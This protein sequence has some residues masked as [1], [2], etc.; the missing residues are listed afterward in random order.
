M[1]NYNLHVSLDGVAW[2]HQEPAYDTLQEATI[3]ALDYDDHFLFLEPIQDAVFETAPEAD[4]DSEPIQ[5]RST[6]RATTVQYAVKALVWLAGASLWIADRTIQLMLLLQQNSRRFAP[7]ER[8]AWPR[9]LKQQLMRRQHSRC[10]Y[11]GNRFSAQYFD[12]DHMMPAAIGGSNEASNLQV[13]CGPCNRRKGDQ[14]DQEFRRRYASLVPQRRLT[15][16]RRPVPQRAFDAVTRSS[17]ASTSVQWR[18]RHRYLTPRE[19]ITIGSGVCGVAVIVLAAWGLTDL[20][21]QDG[22]AVYPAI[23][24]GLTVGVGLWVRARVTGMMSE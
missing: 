18:R 21:L 19:R 3:A 15:P 8:R 14:T 6:L 24:A 7:T 4:R 12:I 11:C 1:P 17:Q 10:A 9:G 5:S 13:L 2:V 20:G 16:P 22:W 23:V